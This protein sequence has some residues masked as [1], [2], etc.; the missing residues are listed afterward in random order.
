VEWVHLAQVGAKARM[1]MAMTLPVLFKAG[2]FLGPNYI[3]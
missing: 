1:N 3:W 2:N